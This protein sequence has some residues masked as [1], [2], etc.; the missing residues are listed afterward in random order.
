MRKDDN[1]IC[2]AFLWKT[3]QRDKEMA[4]EAELQVGHVGLNI[5]TKNNNNGN[6]LF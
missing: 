3:A 1:E 2:N 4:T 5:I 6:E